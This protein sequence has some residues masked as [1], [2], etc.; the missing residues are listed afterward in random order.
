MAYTRASGYRKP[1]EKA[2]V[3]DTLRKHELFDYNQ[4]IK[5][6]QE[7]AA[8]AQEKGSKWGLLGGIGG[9]LLLPL[10][11]TA[12]TMMTGGLGASAFLPTLMSAG[13]NPVYQAA[14]TG[15]GAGLGK[16]YGAKG[17]IDE[18]QA[19]ARNAAGGFQMGAGDVD[20]AGMLDDYGD[21]DDQLK[22]SAI[23]SGLISG[24]TSFALQGGPQFLQQ[25]FAPSGGAGTSF[26]KEGLFGPSGWL[27]QGVLPGSYA[28]PSSYASSLS[29]GQ[30]LINKWLGV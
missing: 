13:V 17:G 14:L 4:S 19:L 18:A 8:D 27:T 7:R 10:A 15:L 29:A 5:E 12:A 2:M 11:A 6:A 21:L 24:A 16:Y 20:V 30:S 1:M 28:T 26:A 22:D 25:K 9:N 23:K 3:L